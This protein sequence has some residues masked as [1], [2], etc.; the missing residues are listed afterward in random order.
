MSVLLRHA[1]LPNDV[2]ARAA[3]ATAIQQAAELVAEAVGEPSLR[4]DPADSDSAGT[5]AD[6]VRQLP[7]AK[8]TAL[9]GLMLQLLLTA[10][11]LLHSGMIVTA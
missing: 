3:Q 5:L 10:N 4:I 7:S 9:A 8:R 11:L 6:R 1:R 2:A